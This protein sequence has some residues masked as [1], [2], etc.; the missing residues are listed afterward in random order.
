MDNQEFDDILWLTAQEKDLLQQV[1]ELGFGSLEDG[2]VTD[3]DRLYPV[4]VRSEEEAFI[5]AFRQH[6]C[7]RE[8]KFSDG[9][10]QMVTVPV[11][12]IAGIQNST[13]KIKL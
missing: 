4:Q 8:L 12:S 6:G 2:H 13:K 10:P 1:K 9:I 5:Q 7:F 11:G 3:I